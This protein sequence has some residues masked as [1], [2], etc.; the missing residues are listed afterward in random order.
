MSNFVI[1]VLALCATKGVGLLLQLPLSE[2]E[3]SASVL[4]IPLYIG[5]FLG[6]SYLYLSIKNK[7]IRKSNEK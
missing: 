4:S 2:R 1:A 7:I 6:L 5:V 3:L